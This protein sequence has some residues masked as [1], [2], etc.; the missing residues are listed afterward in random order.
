MAMTRRTKLGALLAVAVGLAGAG[1]AADYVT[2]STAPVNLYIVALNGGA[3][4]D[5]D[6]RHGSS[7][8][9]DDD[10]LTNPF[11]CEDEI[12]VTVAVRNKNPNAPEPSVPS[13]VLIDSYEV[14]FFR[15]DGRGTEGI[16]V[17]YR[18]TGN[19][20]LAVD[21]SDSDNDAFPIEVVR[22]QAK[23]EPP[24]TSIQQA[25]LLTA[26]AEITL[27]GSTVAGQR[28]SANARM[29]ITFADF[30]DSETSCPT[31]N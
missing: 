21:V 14:R 26:M 5:S 19:L 4:Y 18:I 24:L 10:P 17:P 30:G 15:T 23:L 3:P 31:G 8:A 25:Q 20:R 2:G 27:H 7:L 13:A 16:D 29:Q 12:T 22:R 6:I 1:C 9:F 11:I 28:V